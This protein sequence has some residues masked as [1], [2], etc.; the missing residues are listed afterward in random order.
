MSSIRRNSYLLLGVLPCALAVGY[1]LA[2][3]V[4][5]LSGTHRDVRATRGEREHTV[6]FGVD[7]GGRSPNVDAVL[8][9]N[10]FDSVTGPLLPSPPR[11]SRTVSLSLGSR[12]HR[13]GPR[14]FIIERSAFS[15]LQD[16]MPILLSGAPIVPVYEKGKVVGV[17][18]LGVRPDTIL[19]ALGLEDKDL[20]Q[21]LNGYDL[22][23]PDASLQ[24][25]AN[26]LQAKALLLTVVRGASRI[27]LEY[28]IQ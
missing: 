7:A 3:G 19:G 15:E 13:L 8:S 25:Y 27:T 20:L 1:F 21:S 23:D 17:Q 5:A 26:A 24:A 18:L 10:P 9:R 28:A 4:S 6:V 16:A 12:I 14:Q 22:T 11:D 2:K